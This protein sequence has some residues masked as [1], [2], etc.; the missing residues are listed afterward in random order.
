MALNAQIFTKSTFTQP[1]Y[2]ESF[3]TAFQQNQS[4]NLERSVQF[5]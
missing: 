2:M 1:H 3:R 5:T 4:K